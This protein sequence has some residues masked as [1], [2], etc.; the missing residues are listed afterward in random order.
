VTPSDRAVTDRSGILTDLRIVDLTTG[1]A[2]P[3]ATN[4]LAELGAEVVK[5]EKPAGDPARSEIPHGYR[6]WNRSKVVVEGDIG[7]D[8]AR[9]VLDDLLAAAD[10][11]VHE[12]T[13]AEAAQAG[14]DPES[15]AERFPLLIV[16]SVTGY[17]PGHPDA[18]LPASE[19]LVLARLGALDE[20][21]GL[22]DGPIFIRYPFAS[23][24]AA[25]L[26][27]G[28]ILVRA[29]QR[30]RGRGVAP[31]HTSLLQGALVPAALY[32]HRAED[33]PDWMIQHTLPKIDCPPHLSLFECRDGRWIQLVGG[34]T[35]SLAVE[36]Q[37][38]S[39]GLRAL[40]GTRVTRATRDSWVPVF[41]AR[42]CDDWLDDLWK[43][44]VPCMPVL[45]PGELF[46]RE[47]A[48][49]NRYATEVDDPELGR[50]IQVGFPIATEPPAQVHRGEVSDV[51]TVA[52]R[53][54]GAR[55][56]G[57]AT[58]SIA[59]EPAVGWSGSAGPLHGVRV[60]DFGAYVAGPLGAQCLA[61]FGADVVKIEPLGGEKARSINQFTGCQRGK[62][63]LALDLRHA[64]SAGVIERLIAR[65]DV[66]THNMRASAATK[67]GIDDDTIRRINPRAVIATST[68]YGANGP[69]AH[70]PA[71]DPTALALSGVATMIS[72]PGR[73]SF[74][75]NSSMDSQ[76]GL[77][78]FVATMVG[79]YQR[80]ITG[81][82]AKTGTSLL[83]VAAQA[84]S[85]TLVINGEPQPITTVD[86][87]Q[88]GTSSW[89]TRMYATRDGWIAVDATTDDQQSALLAVGRAVQT[90]GVQTYDV[91]PDH[92]P[93][94]F[95][96]L[97]STE[98]YDQLTAAGV[99]SEIVVVNGR[100][101]FF[102]QELARG[103]SLVV[104][105]V[106][107]PYGW[108]ETPGGYWSDR[109]GTVRGA[110]GLADVGEHTI[111]I[112]TELGYQP[113]EV[114]EL[115]EAAVVGAGTAGR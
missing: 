99:P 51:A 111:E 108:L 83:A 109:E 13:P 63:S 66:V 76:T 45:H 43:E 110:D 47:Q 36:R 3:A 17:P 62:R 70:L 19:L 7:G 44:D 28:G 58:P 87:D 2:G 14:F 27:A 39:M 38:D 75:R 59:E 24:G 113:H 67:L 101:R 34:F 10:V 25:W 78:L 71:F 90:D 29:W 5:V 31:I 53:W 49:V 65:A 97:T 112:L 114:D 12:M 100:D 96:S 93:E 42:N 68:A 41:Q 105:M 33:P 11:V 85:E 37:L 84:S 6:S 82:G 64:D 32:W 15:L 88:L 9:A 35:K 73:P 60:L 26:L 81:T 103:S 69:W 104:R 8:A 72:G 30:M 18:E 57:R 1:I 94:A 80:E 102:D 56:N 16:A 79:L 4:I 40:A 55:A 77:A 107:S 21:E 23:W 61:D 106:G 74:L 89:S 20:Q 50:T 52:E 86:S 54:A 98:L 48:L 95:V 91:Q 92:L 22:R 115:I 46:T